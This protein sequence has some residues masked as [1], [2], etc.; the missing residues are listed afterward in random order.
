MH[1]CKDL[2]VNSWEGYMYL[3]HYVGT[4]FE[5]DTVLKLFCL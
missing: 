1:T 3:L 4:G 2:T 5:G